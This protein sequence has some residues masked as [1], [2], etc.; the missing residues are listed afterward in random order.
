MDYT[1]LYYNRNEFT[2]LIE[3]INLQIECYYSLSL[4]IEKLKLMT[5]IDKNTIELRKKINNLEENTK[6]SS[7][8][9]GIELPNKKD[10]YNN[11]DIITHSIPI[12]KIM[13]IYYYYNKSN[14]F[15]KLKLLKYNRN[16]IKC[17]IIESNNNFECNNTI[18][19]NIEH[20]TKLRIT[21]DKDNYNIGDK[22]AMVIKNIHILQIED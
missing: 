18:Y 8:F 22:P 20:L 9:Q 2:R 17:E 3:L 16:T 19:N 5:E 12:N 11:N 7:I 10:L 21:K 15:Y 4:G 13:Y 1:S 14:Y 6:I